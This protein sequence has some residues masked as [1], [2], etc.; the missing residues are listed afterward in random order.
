MTITVLG[1]YNGC[2]DTATP[3]LCSFKGCDR[4]VKNKA[5]QLCGGHYAQIRRG[6]PLTPLLLPGGKKN[7]G[8]CEYSLCR[9]QATVM[10]MCDAHYRQFRKG[11]PLSEVKKKNP[12]G[13]GSINQDGYRTISMPGHFAARADGR[14]FEHVY[15]MAEHLGRRLWPGE[16]VHHK[17][18]DRLDNRLENLELWVTMQPRGQRPEDLVEYAQEILMR[19]AS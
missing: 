3:S 14:M 17:N 12:S 2:M 5:R 1:L 7:V 18:G 4:N 10:R 6:K 16:N 8:Q 11:E 19:Y 13:M 9:R 15:V